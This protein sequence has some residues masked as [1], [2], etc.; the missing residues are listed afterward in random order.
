VFALAVVASSWSAS[1]ADPIAV[2][3]GGAGD[4]MPIHDLATPADWS[5]FYAGVYGLGQGSS[6]G[7]GQLGLG[8]M[9]GVNAQFEMV[10]LGAEVAVQGFGGGE[11]GAT[12]YGELLGR[13]GLLVTDDVSVYAA[14]GYGMDLGGTGQGDVLLGGGVE[15]AVSESVSLRGQYL[16]SFPTQEGIAKDQLTLGAV[17]HF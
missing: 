11:R 5:G 16:H 8:V 9:A 4:N 15:M 14:A 10:L 6:D 3:L 2:S 17:F 7:G 13:A 1:A 12:A